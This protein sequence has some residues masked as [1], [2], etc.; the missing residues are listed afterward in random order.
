MHP[1]YHSAKRA[2]IT[3]ILGHRGRQQA[4]R[5]ARPQAA[6]PALSGSLSACATLVGRAQR[7]PGCG[8]AVAGPVTGRASP[9]PRRA[10]PPSVKGLFRG[11]RG[12]SG[13]RGA[14]EYG[15]ESMGVRG[16]RCTGGL[17]TRRLASPAA[18]LLHEAPRAALA[19]RTLAALG[20]K[21]YLMSDSLIGR[22]S[23]N[24]P[25]IW[26]GWVFRWGFGGV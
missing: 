20:S 23:G 4:H 19:A 15:Q 18:A 6:C 12:V 2:G 17:S 24:S 9:S 25:S 26:S 22:R 1:R 5:M 10:P 8:G 13:I 16:S 11:R 14:E 21:T 3:C 7:D